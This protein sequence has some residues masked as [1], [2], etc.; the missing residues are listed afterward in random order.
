[1]KAL[2]AEGTVGQRRHGL[3]PPRQA[4]PVRACARPGLRHRSKTACGCGCWA[5]QRTQAN[6]SAG[7]AIAQRRH[8]A[9]RTTSR[10]ARWRST[11]QP[12]PLVGICRPLQDPARSTRAVGIGGRCPQ[13]GISHNAAPSAFVT[14]RLVRTPSS[15]CWVWV[16][17]TRRR[18]TRPGQQDADHEQRQPL[19]GRRVPASGR[20]RRRAA[21][22]GAASVRCGL[23]ASP[24]SGSFCD[25][26]WYM[27]GSPQVPA[28]TVHCADR[29]RSHAGPA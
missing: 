12:D 3:S 19:A 22:S 29:Q 15:R 4:W 28:L 27:Y 5:G 20:R 26:W 1:V 18:T 7:R 14:G 6:G 9:V 16:V 21:A 25:N 8:Q 11:I 2:A 13:L 10:V 17:A 24:E 23:L